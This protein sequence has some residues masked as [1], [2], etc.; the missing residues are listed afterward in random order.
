M[1]EGEEET[2]FYTSLVKS[3]ISP[4]S[5]E[6]AASNSRTTASQIGRVFACVHLR[7]SGH[8]TVSSQI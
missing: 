4:E 5:A 7:G 1:C 2:W 3:Q 8:L 6:G